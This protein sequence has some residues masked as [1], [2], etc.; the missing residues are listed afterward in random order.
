MVVRCIMWPIYHGVIWNVARSTWNVAL[1]V[2]RCVKWDAMWDVA[3][4]GVMRHNCGRY[5]WCDLIYGIAK[6][7]SVLWG[8]GAI[9]N[10]WC[11]E[12]NDGVTW[13][14]VWFGI[15]VRSVEWCS[16]KCGGLMWWGARCNGNV[17]HIPD[18]TTTAQQYFTSNHISGTAHHTTSHSSRISIP[19]DHT[20]WCGIVWCGIWCMCN[21]L[22]CQ[23][24]DVVPYSS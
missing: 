6:W 9:W 11:G 17:L 5:Q 2:E 24:W 12:R 16:V 23:M 3:W 21:V 7:K 20:A 1:Y 22:Q 15:N 10:V 18:L 13:N 4:C 19:P 8:A 14:V